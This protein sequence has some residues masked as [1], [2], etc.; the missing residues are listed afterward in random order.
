MIIAMLKTE[1]KLLFVIQK[2]LIRERDAISLIKSKFNDT[3]L[4]IFGGKMYISLLPIFIVRFKTYFCT[5]NVQ[6]V[7]QNWTSLI[8]LRLNVVMVVWF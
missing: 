5:F 3:V 2:E 8:W 4:T 1:K 6:F 7:L